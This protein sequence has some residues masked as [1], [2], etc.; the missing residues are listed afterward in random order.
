MDEQ[1]PTQVEI[2][3]LTPAELRALERALQWP[4]DVAAWDRANTPTNMATILGS[5][6]TL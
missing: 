2:I 4:E 6:T 3:E 5:M 1:T